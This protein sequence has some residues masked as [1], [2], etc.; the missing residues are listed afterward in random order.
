MQ[1]SRAAFG[2]RQTQMDAEDKGEVAQGPEPS[3]LSA[4]PS[5]RHDS[6]MPAALHSLV[7]CQLQHRARLLLSIAT[8]I[9]GCYVLTFSL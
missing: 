1:P 4:R 9:M 7:A 2:R 3:V 8:N 6:F 5:T